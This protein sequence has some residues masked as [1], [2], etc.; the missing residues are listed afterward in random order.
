MKLVICEQKAKHWAA[1]IPS[2][3][4][5]QKKI[6]MS[7]PWEGLTSEGPGLMANALEVDFGM[8]D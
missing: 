3:I 6:E 2:S 4:S 7:S 1:Y 5:A 8:Q